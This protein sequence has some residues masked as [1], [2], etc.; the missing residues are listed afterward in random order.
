M[1]EKA[2]RQ[3]ELH[4]V[5]V[6][7]R[8]MDAARMTF[9]S[10]SFQNIIFPFNGF[11]NIPGRAQREKVIQD[12]FTILKPEGCFILTSRSGIGFGRRWLAWPPLWGIYI[13]QRHILGRSY[14]LGDK[15]WKG[16]YYHYQS[17]FSLKVLLRNAGFRILFFNSEKN[18]LRGKGASFFTNFSGDRILFYVLRKDR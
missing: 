4:N 6:D 11:D 18:L 7:F 16:E 12:I 5:E 1:I 17:P 2:K 3:A 9:P 10:E 8:V 15:I 13:V 14:E